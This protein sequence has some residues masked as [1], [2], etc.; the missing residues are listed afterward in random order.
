MYFHETFFRFGS[1]TILDIT[2]VLYFF[3]STHVIWLSHR[4]QWGLREFGPQPS[5]PTHAQVGTIAATSGKLTMKT[6][7]VIG[8]LG[9]VVAFNASFSPEFNVYEEHKESFA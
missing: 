9:E 1:L 8:E 6:Q 3:D 7:G 4:A 5:D 2:D